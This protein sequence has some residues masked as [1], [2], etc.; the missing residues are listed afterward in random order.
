[1]GIIKINSREEDVD[2]LVSTK[3][4][5]KSTLGD[6]IEDAL[7]KYC[8]EMEAKFFFGLTAKDIKM[9]EFQLAEKNGK[10]HPFPN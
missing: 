7:V 2:K 1:M 10:C 8:L 5:R 3:L 9:M 6:E 4:G